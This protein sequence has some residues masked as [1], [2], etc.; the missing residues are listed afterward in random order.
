MTTDTESAASPALAVAPG[1]PIRV[2]L[3]RRR[4]WRK[5]P[6]CIVVSRPAK[7]GNPHKV[8][9]YGGAWGALIGVDLGD[10]NGQILTG[11]DKLFPTAKEARAYAVELY[12]QYLATKPELMA[13]IAELRGRSLACWCPL[14][15]PCHADVLLRLANKEV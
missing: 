9:E 8:I 15:H 3:S 7:W 11:F 10:R 4:G 1:S 5:P 12:E 2:Q 14:D 6:N 13:Q